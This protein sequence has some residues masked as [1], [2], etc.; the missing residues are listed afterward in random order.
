MSD[1]DIDV[2]DS[3]G[4]RKYIEHPVMHKV[5][6]GGNY[7]FSMRKRILFDLKKEYYF[8]SFLSILKAFE[9]DDRFETAFYVGPNEERKWGFIPVYR[10]SGIERRLRNRG[11][12]VVSSPAGFDAVVAAD[13]L[14]NP[15]R[16]G[17][18]LLFVSDHGPGT[19]TLRFRNIARQK[20][21]RYVVFV[22]GRYWMDV[23]KRFGFENAAEW[24]M[25]GVPK[26]DT[27]FWE[28]YYDREK[29]LTG[30]HLDPTRK[31]VLYAPSYRPSCIPFIKE[32]IARVADSCNL[33]IKLHPYS[34]EG[35]YASPG[36]SSL[37]VKLTGKDRRIALVPR[38]D[39]DFHP[40]MFAAD[41]VISDTSSALA[42]C[43]AHK[44][45]GIVADFPYPRM[46]HSDGIPIVSDEPH[47]YLTDVFVHFSRVE[48][49]TDA[50]AHAVN[51][52]AE[53]MRKLLE[54]R[55]Y[56][57]TGL[58]GKAGERAKDCIAEKVIGKCRA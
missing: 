30:L 49:L 23:I 12:T 25:T 5:I 22:E 3:E 34:W 41:T 14:K 13:A 9:K 11:L 53:M 28:G 44:K 17:N 24:V 57:F 47:D 58:D 55:G 56:Y 43:L 8:N 40:Y 33:I 20:D 42:I 37:Y 4:I 18:P 10:K 32:K 45:V 48:D 27:L 7:F 35:K 54:Y 2:S 6:E 15:E 19:K 38:D 51:P 26:L 16:Y 52:S 1:F 36:Q 29:I 39:F 31:T 46:T 50:V 21:R